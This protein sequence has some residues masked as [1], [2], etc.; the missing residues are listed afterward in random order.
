MFPCA[1]IDALSGY[2]HLL[3]LYEPQNIIL[4]GDSAGGGL[5]LSLLQALEEMKL[6]M[7]GGAVLFSPW[8]DLTH[9]FPGFKENGPF[10]YLPEASNRANFPAHMVDQSHLYAPD[11]HLNHGLVS[12]WF[13]STKNFPPLLI[14][15]GTHE[16]LYEENVAYAKKAAQTGI[17]HL[18]AFEDQVHVFQAFPFKMAEKAFELIGHFVKQLAAQSLV[19]ESV[20]VTS[21]FDVNTVEQL[22]NP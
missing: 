7:P 12:P 11:A 3:E 19:S 21:Q 14:Q 17:V 10:D 15:I 4:N 1:L 2:I 22:S 20:L 18:Q 13:G 9:S 8:V 5:C 6:P 16:R